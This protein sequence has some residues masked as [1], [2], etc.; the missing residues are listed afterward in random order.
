[1]G[2]QDAYRKKYAVFAVSEADTYTFRTDWSHAPITSLK[3]DA[4]AI[5]TVKRGEVK[6]FTAT[7]NE[8][9]TTDYLEWTTANPALATVDAN[10]LVTVKNVIG[11]VI[12]TA[13][14]PVSERSH[15]VLLRIAS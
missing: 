1:L 7:V 13:K 8:G 6:Q 5:V 3:I 10:G 12:L 14:D 11:T 4:I 2:I 15:S 9:A